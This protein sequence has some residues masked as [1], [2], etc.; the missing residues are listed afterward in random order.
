M[1]EPASMTARA[2][3]CPLAAMW[4]DH[5]DTI[6]SY[7]KLH[8]GW[9]PFLA[10]DWCACSSRRCRD[11]RRRTDR[12]P[13]GLREAATGARGSRCSSSAGRAL[14]ADAVARAF[15]DAVTRGV[16]RRAP[17]GPRVA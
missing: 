9:L 17:D 2:C 3:G 8:G 7:E 5:L 14:D 6:R 12:L 4:P 1:G 10:T 16:G 15:L 13:A 11:L